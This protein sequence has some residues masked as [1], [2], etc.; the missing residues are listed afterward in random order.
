MV[1]LR[2]R[3]PSI[4]QRSIVQSILVGLYAYFAVSG[5]SALINGAGAIN[6]FLNFMIQAEPFLLLASIIYIPFDIE[7]LSRFRNWIFAFGAIHLILAF[8]QFIGLETG[9][10]AHQRMTMED[11]VQGVFYLSSGG[12]VVGGTVAFIYGIYFLLL[13]RVLA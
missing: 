8:G 9:L 10:I 11:N 6:I 5:I 4:R 3:R 1:Y 7:K 13:L 2:C 12:H